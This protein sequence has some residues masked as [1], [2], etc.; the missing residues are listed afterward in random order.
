LEGLIVVVVPLCHGSI[1]DLL[2]M[3]KL[4]SVGIVEESP[5]MRPNVSVGS[6]GLLLIQSYQCSSSSNLQRDNRKTASSV[7]DKSHEVWS[8]APCSMELHLHCGMDQQTMS[9][10][11]PR[12]HDIS[13]EIS[14]GMDAKFS[15]NKSIKSYLHC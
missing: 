4:Q 2:T 13:L 11:V 8:T 5:M 7:Y 12:S 9:A 6:K 10:K 3:T 14:S 1:V 15:T